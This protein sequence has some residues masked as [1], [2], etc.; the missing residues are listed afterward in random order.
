MSQTYSQFFLL[1]IFLLLRPFFNSQKFEDKTN[2]FLPSKRKRETFETVVC[3]HSSFLLVSQ[4]YWPFVVLFIILSQRQFFYCQKLEGKTNSSLPSKRKRE[5]VETIFC[6]HSSF[7]LVSQAY[8]HFFVLFIFLYRRPFF[9]CQKFESKTNSFFPSKRKK[10]TFETV[11]CCDC[12]C[13]L[14]KSRVVLQNYIRFC[15]TCRRI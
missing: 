13:L 11:F 4:T 2:S 8:S 12:S 14:W 7:L 9:C 5:T 6:C 10:D 15:S 3:C 1:F